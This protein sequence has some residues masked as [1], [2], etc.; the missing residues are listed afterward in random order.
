MEFELSWEDPIGRIILIGIL[1]AIAL[2]IVFSGYIFGGG[3]KGWKNNFSYMYDSSTNGWTEIYLYNV[4][5]DKILIDPKIL[6]VESIT[7]KVG[8]IKKQ[9][10][11]ENA[12][13]LEPY[14]QN[15]LTVR[16]DYYVS[17][18]KITKIKFSYELYE[19]SQLPLGKAS[20][21]ISA[22]LNQHNFYR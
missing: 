13:P 22:L 8:S 21:Q 12:Q 5:D 4:S 15:Y 16:L 10:D 11:V 3:N 17:K 1:V 6:T 9:V 2:V 18:L 14:S 20:S 19:G 7:F